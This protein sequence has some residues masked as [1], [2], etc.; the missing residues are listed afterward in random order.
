MKKIISIS[1]LLLVSIALVTGCG[2][3]KDTNKESEN[4]TEEQT[5][6]STAEVQGD[7]KV[8]DIKIKSEGATSIVTGKI[9]NI[10]TLEKNVHVSLFMTD[11]KAGKLLGIVETDMNALRPNET[12]DF[13]LSIVG[14]YSQ[15]DTFEVRTRE[16][17]I[18]VNPEPTPEPVPEV[19][20]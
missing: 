3:K 12:R 10:S 14:D 5:K 2:K 11:S 16:K 7:Y 13:E 17:F 6:N 15:A 4:K 9:T 20:E 19:T 18:S 8:T 1:L